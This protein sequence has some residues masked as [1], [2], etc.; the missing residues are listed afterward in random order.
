MKR[1]LS[2][3]NALHYFCAITDWHVTYKKKIDS[4]IVKA[5]CLQL[6]DGVNERGKKEGGGGSFY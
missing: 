1:G 3:I 2:L 5:N 6:L 4:F